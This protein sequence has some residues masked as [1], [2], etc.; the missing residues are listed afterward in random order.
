MVTRRVASDDAEGTTRD[1]AGI[2]RALS[3]IREALRGLSFGQLTVTVHDGA[4]VQ[5]DRTEK[6]R[7][8][9]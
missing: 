6:I 8:R 1:E 9:S 2:E 4:I 7:V 5:L 3:Q